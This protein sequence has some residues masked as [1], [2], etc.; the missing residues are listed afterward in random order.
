MNRAPTTP[1]ARG[2]GGAVIISPTD[3]DVINGKGQ[4][5]QRLKGNADYRKAVKA[6][7]VGIVSI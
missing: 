4:G 6:H 5:V 2:G 7:K 1:S 3:R